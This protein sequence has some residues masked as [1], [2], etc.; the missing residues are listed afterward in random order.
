[1]AIEDPFDLSH[2]LGGFLTGR[3]R[4]FI[5][6]AFRR[7]RLIFGT[8][9]SQVPDDFDSYEEYLFSRQALYPGKERPTDRLCRKCGHVGH[10]SRDC[11]RKRQ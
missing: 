6:Q 5:L 2:N 4:N 9:L 10:S 11:K 8:P 1:M 3:M 7:A